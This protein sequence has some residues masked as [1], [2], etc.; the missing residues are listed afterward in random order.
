MASAVAVA[1]V[2]V[3]AAEADSDILLYR[4]EKAGNLFPGLIVSLFI[5]MR[6]RVNN[7]I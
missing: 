3:A 2:T 1:A 4:K 7:Y 6:V 5:Y